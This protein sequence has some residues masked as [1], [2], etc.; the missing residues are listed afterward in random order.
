MASVGVGS[1]E[2]DIK[3]AGIF[4]I[5]HGV[6]TL[7]ID[8]GIVGHAPPPARIEA[9]VEAGALERGVR[10]GAGRARCASSWTTG[11]AP[12]SKPCG[13]ATWSGRRW[14][15]PSQLST[16]DRDILRDALRIV[17]Q[18]R[19]IIRNRYNLGAF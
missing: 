3:K 5:V 8:R 16:A 4:P 12:S 7:A 9:L 2:I 1:D 15:S 17:R 13:A 19:E 10:A 14:C 11:C 6:R 18:F